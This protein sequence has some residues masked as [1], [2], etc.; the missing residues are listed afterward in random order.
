MFG[1]EAIDCY[2]FPRQP[3]FLFTTKSIGAGWE[4]QAERIYEM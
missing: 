4:R 1:G 2:R 3:G